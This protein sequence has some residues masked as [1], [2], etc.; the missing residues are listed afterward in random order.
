MSF[1][2]SK[3]AVVIT[4][5]ATINVAITRNGS[6]I[7][8]LVGLLTGMCS[9]FFSMSYIYNIKKNNTNQLTIAN[10]FLDGQHFESDINQ[11]EIKWDIS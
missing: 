3:T 4:A 11:P 7:F 10:T 8:R 2:A 1:E 9:K 5:A 6:H